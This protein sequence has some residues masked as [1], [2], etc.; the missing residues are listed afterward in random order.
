MTSL[1]KLNLAF[2]NDLQEFSFA[3]KKKVHALG[4]VFT[5]Q[6]AQ[7]ARMGAEL[8]AYYPSFLKSIRQLDAVLEDLDDCPDWT[9]E[10][11]LLEEPTASRVSEAEFSQPL[12]TAIQVALVQLLGLW[13]IRPSVTCGHSSGE[14]AAAYAA[15]FL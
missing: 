6:G 8:M 15:G 11:L 7:W 2:E 10:D 1:A 13:Q 4:F 12:C 14:I 9:L 3:D 5:G